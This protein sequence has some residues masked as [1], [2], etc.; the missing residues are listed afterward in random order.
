MTTA[1]D[2]FQYVPHLRPEPEEYIDPSRWGHFSVLRKSKQGQRAEQ[3]SYPLYKLHEVIAECADPKSDYWISQAVFSKHNRRKANLKSVGVSFVDLDYYKIG[4][5]W[6]LDGEKVL[7]DYV[8][9]E[10]QRRKIP[11]PSLVMDS[12]CGLQLKWFTEALPAKALPRWDRLQTELCAALEHIGGDK[13]SKDAS[14]VLRLQGTVNQK[15]G[16]P[17]R[18]LW[19]DVGKDCLPHR[20]TFDD[21]CNAVLPFTRER[22]AELRELRE[23][24]AQGTRFAAKQ[25]GKA[26]V[27][28]MLASGRARTLENLNWHRLQDLKK[29][30][31]LRGGDVGDGLREPLA[32]YMCNFYALRYAQSG[33]ADMLV[34]HEFY[35]LCKL[36]APHWG[37]AY[38]TGKVSNVFGLMKKQAEGEMKEWQGREVPMLYVPR[39]QTMIDLFGITTDEQRELATIIDSREKQRRNTDQ[40]TEARRKQGVQARSEYNQERQD[41]AAERMQRVLMLTS[42]GF[43]QGDIAQMM[44]ITINAVKSLKKRALSGR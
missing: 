24:R 32:F 10:L 34:W 15:T 27:L 7:F 6:Q 20:Y 2:I 36:A 12:G 44:G 31:E 43:K 5:L 33:L 28:K 8:F 26:D 41:I 18:V 16:Q 17:V 3:R 37:R 25:S 19:S 13:H 21:L 42:Q 30:I 14:R 1:L 11:L 23:Q 35:Q 40:H 38:A 22:L 9:P 29:L 39:N 4:D